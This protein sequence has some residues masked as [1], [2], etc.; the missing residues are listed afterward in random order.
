MF[1]TIYVPQSKMKRT[2]DAEGP[3]SD[4][5]H[6]SASNLDEA[7]SCMEILQ[8]RNRFKWVK[9]RTWADEKLAQLI[10]TIVQMSIPKSSLKIYPDKY[11]IEVYTEGPFNLPFGGPRYTV[12]YKGRKTEAIKKQIAKMIKKYWAE[13]MEEAAK[14][15][16]MVAESCQKYL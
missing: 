3:T 2:A 15:A 5:N 7:G 1:I 14:E 11:S 12:S 6:I 10:R 9:D 4:I 13:K 8:N 16:E